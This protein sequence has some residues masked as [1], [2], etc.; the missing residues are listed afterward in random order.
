MQKVTTKERN[1]LEELLMSICK[2][3]KD[4]KFTKIQNFIAKKL[5]IKKPMVSK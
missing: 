3:K 2:C 1:E 4:K 5:A